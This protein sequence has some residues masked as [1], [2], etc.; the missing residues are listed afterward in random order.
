MRF[1]LAKDW[2]Y[3]YGRKYHFNLKKMTFKSPPINGG[4]D[5]VVIE[6]VAR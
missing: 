3:N 5:T 2:Q 4:D 6:P 1:V